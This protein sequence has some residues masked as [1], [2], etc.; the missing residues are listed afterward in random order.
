M[1]T[2]PDDVQKRVF[3]RVVDHGSLLRILLSL[4][5]GRT[6]RNWVYPF[7]GDFRA[8]LEY[9]PTEIWEGNHALEYCN[10]IVNAC[11]KDI[12][13]KHTI[14]DTSFE[15]WCGNQ[16][17]KNLATIS[18]YVNAW[19]ANYEASQQPVADKDFLDSL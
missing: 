14:S 5:P 19:L 4:Q 9:K 16:L 7:F 2:L 8:T 17:K 6:N 15:A 10:A 13:K 3:E 11:E 1:K 12:E 18:R